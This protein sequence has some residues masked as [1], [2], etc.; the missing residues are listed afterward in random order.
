MSLSS[1]RILGGWT[2]LIGGTLISI[3][4]CGTRSEQQ[5]IS[6]LQDWIKANK[7][8]PFAIARADWGPGT[9]VTFPHGAEE[10]VAFDSDC[11]NL[12]QAN[13]VSK[14]AVALVSGSYSIND[15]D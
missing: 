13:L 5:S 14:T 2:A 11:L 7:Y 6:P 3:C 12:Q 9:L 15:S 1:Y 10:I 8:V 4:S